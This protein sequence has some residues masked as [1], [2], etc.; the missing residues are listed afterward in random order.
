VVGRRYFLFA[1]APLHSRFSIR[2]EMTNSA[3]RLRRHVSMELRP[4]TTDLAAAIAVNEA[5][6]W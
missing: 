6:Q 5:D 1:R 4:K 3:T 2:N